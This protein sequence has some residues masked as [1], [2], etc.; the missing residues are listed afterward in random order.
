MTQPVLRS[1]QVSLPRSFGAEGATDP[2]DRPWVSGFDKQPVAGPVRLGATNLDGDGQADLVYHGGP[3]KAVLAYSADHYDDWRR[4]LAM[5]AL[6]F[7][8]FGENFTIAGQSEAEV[9]VGDVWQVGAVT[10][11]VSQPRQPCW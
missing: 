4:E 6:R 3:D 10:L 9:C 2:L 1:I 7:G 11:Q 8:A 5:P